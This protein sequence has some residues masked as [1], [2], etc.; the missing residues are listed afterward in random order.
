M[1]SYN[2]HQ[3]YSYHYHWALPNN[4]QLFPIHW[5]IG[6]YC[7]FLTVI[8]QIVLFLTCSSCSF[9]SFKLR[10]RRS[11]IIHRKFFCVYCTLFGFETKKASFATKPHSAVVF[12]ELGLQKYEVRCDQECLITGCS[13]A[14]NHVSPK[15]WRVFALLMSWWGIFHKDTI[16]DGGSTAL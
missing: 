11:A 12:S 7:S 13:I 1:Q 8:T 3:F 10:C 16:R 9:V 2:H 14:S 5:L 6:C 15:F 4:T